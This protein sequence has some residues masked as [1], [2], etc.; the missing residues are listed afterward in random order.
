MKKY[1]FESEFNIG[2][3]VYHA[4]ADSDRGIVV[5]IA[6]SA[7]TNQVSYNV[8]F[9]RHGSDNVYCWGDELS[10]DKYFN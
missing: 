8:V 1:I 9:G 10:T 4:T 5:D 7:K 6:F 3:T 2:D